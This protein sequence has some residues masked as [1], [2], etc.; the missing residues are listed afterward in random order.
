MNVFNIINIYENGQEQPCLP[1]ADALEF[2]FQGLEG[3]SI[4]IKGDGMLLITDTGGARLS[5]KPVTAAGNPAKVDGVPIWTVADPSLL[6]L[7]VDA[8]N[9][10]LATIHAAGPVGT[11]Q[12]NVQADADLGEGVRAIAGVLDV[13]IEAGEAVSLDIGAEVLPQ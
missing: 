6:R 10:L 13:Q 11:T 12:V 4:R 5:I 7:E 9:P 3:S 8:E 2:W 1:P